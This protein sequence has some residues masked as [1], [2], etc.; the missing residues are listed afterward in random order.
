M[1]FKVTKDD[2]EKPLCEEVLAKGENNISDLLNS[3]QS[4]LRQREIQDDAD[5]NQ[6]E[7]IVLSV[8]NVINQIK[9]A[10]K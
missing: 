1:F 6:I 5:I 10:R 3:L 7:S 2:L 8:K 4:T 9:A